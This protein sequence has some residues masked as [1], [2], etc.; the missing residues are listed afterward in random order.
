MST[1]QTPA[2]Q[3]PASARSQPNSGGSQKGAPQ[4]GTRTVL[5]HTV[6]VVATAAAMLAGVWILVAAGTGFSFGWQDGR[7]T[8]EV[9]SQDAFGKV[10]DRFLERDGDDAEAL[11]RERGFFRTSSITPEALGE[12]VAMKIA[13]GAASEGFTIEALRQQQFYRL[14]D[15]TLIQAL[16]ELDPDEP[17]SHQLRAMLYQRQGPFGAPSTLAEADGE[18]LARALSDLSQSHPLKVTMWSNFVGFRW[19]FMLPELK[20]RVVPV[21]TARGI[22]APGSGPSAEV[23]YVCPGSELFGKS[24]H[25]WN[26]EQTV[27]LAVQ[28]RGRRLPQDCTN[29]L[30]QLVDLFKGEV[31]V[32]LSRAT[33]DASFPDAVAAGERSVLLNILVYPDGFAP[34]PVEPVGG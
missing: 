7:P 4:G 8:L 9:K 34:L 18:F 20:V 3:T 33:F 11:L 27:S 25:L 12:V 28:A 14:R 24:L 29:A 2:S 30:L 26:D 22:Q 16:S 10:V 31:E 6:T 5:A 21:S 17:F 19:D 13:E 15:A 1:D 23:A 32:G